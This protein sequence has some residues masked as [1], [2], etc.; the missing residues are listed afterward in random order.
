MD[1]WMGVIREEVVLTLTFTYSVTH[2]CVKHCARV[3]GTSQEKENTV[4]VL[5][6][7]TVNEKKQRQVIPTM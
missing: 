1:G 7:P 4:L 5:C 2:I 3:G 6:R